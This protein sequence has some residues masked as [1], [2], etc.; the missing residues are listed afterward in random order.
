MAGQA[1]PGGARAQTATLL[2]LLERH[3]IKRGSDDLQRV[4][5]AVRVRVEALPDEA[6]ATATVQ[7][8]QRA[9]GGRLIEDDVTPRWFADDEYSEADL[10]AAASLL[11]TQRDLRGAME[12]LTGRYSHLHSL[13]GRIDDLDRVIAEAVAAVE[14]G[15]AA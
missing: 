4:R 1:N 12:G 2:A 14:S 10:E 11:R 7:R 8:Y 6:A 9:L 5:E 3:Y 15:G 13:R